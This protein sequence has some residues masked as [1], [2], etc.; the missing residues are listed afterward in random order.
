VAQRNADTHDASES[1]AP[2]PPVLI[3]ANSAQ[4]PSAW[5]PPASRPLSSPIRDIGTDLWSIKTRW[6]THI[7]HLPDGMPLLKNPLL[8]R[9]TKATSIGSFA[10]T[11][12][13]SHSGH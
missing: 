4:Q 7:R 9:L 13:P 11:I 3:P 5:I 1:P 10:W 12:T 2:R 6:I 8:R